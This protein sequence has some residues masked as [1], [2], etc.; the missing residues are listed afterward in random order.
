[1]KKIITGFMLC[2]MLIVTCMNDEVYAGVKVL[3]WDLVD[4]GKH[5]DWD[6]STKYMKQFKSAVNVWNGYKKGVIRK[7]S[8]FRIQDVA[9]SDCFEVSSTAGVTGSNGVIR[10]NKYIMDRLSYNGQ[11]NVCIH[12]LG[13]ALGLDHNTSRDIMYMY[14]T[15][16]V[17]LS[18]N[19]KIS[20]NYAYKYRYK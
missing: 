10:F 12:E 13:H 17:A 9:I 6:G 15:N 4:S 7:D 20:Y 11:K 14:A 18:Y 2:M 19:D 16:R 3:N 1:M 5:L 8:L